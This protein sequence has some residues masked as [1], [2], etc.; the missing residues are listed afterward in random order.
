MSQVYSSIS[1]PFTWAINL[2]GK[3][4]DALPPTATTGCGRPGFI[5]EY[6]NDPLQC[7]LTFDTIVKNYTA[8]DKTLHVHLKEMHGWSALV[9]VTCGGDAPLAGSSI[10]V[11]GNYKHLDFHFNF[12]SNVMCGGL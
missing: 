11:E 5:S 9:S 6:G 2:C 12:T 1:T 7:I 3:G 10:P 4:T 8:H